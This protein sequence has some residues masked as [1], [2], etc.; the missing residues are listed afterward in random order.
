MTILLDDLIGDHNLGSPF[1][2]SEE[3]QDSVLGSFHV[4]LCQ[5]IP[6]STFNDGHKKV[7]NFEA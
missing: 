6:L 3:K 2:S 4:L 7:R 5:Q 1:T